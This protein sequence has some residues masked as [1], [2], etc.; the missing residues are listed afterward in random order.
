MSSSKPKFL[1]RKD[2]DKIIAAIQKAERDTSG[3]IRVHIEFEPSKNHLEKAVEVFNR[4]GMDQTKNRNGVLFHVSPADHFFTIIGD[5]GID[6][7]TP[8]GFWDEINTLVLNHFKQ[9]NY[10]KGLCEGIKKTGK[11]LKK[12]FPYQDDDV[13]E[14]P[15]EISYS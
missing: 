5:R 3:E 1:T 9:E 14:L 11:V 6:E 15:D 13:N 12:H 4:L 10:V 7:V 2:E 8:E